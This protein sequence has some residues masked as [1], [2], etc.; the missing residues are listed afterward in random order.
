MQARRFDSGR[1]PTGAELKYLDDDS[2]WVLLTCNADLV[3]CRDIFRSSRSDTVKLSVEASH[4]NGR[5][6]S[7][8]GSINGSIV[9]RF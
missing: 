4:H 6:G 2:E 8:W 7:S 3:K 9:F 5:L 1:N